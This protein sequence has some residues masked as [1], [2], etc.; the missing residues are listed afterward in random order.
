M[1]DKHQ[2]RFKKKLHLLEG[3]KLVDLLILQN[4]QKQ[5]KLNPRKMSDFTV[6]CVLEQ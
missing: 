2:S 5:Q 3:M 1:I 4:T 6:S